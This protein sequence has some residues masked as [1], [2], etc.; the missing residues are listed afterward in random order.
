MSH[1]L[2]LAHRLIVDVRRYPREV[3]IAVERLPGE[4]GN[5]LIDSVLRVQITRETAGLCDSLVSAAVQGP[6]S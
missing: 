4:S 6:S 2:V 1:C 5:A 3:R